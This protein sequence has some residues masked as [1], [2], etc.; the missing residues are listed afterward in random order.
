MSDNT[1]ID[2]QQQQQPSNQLIHYNTVKAQTL[3]GFV[4]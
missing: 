3:R 2:Q 1:K 4:N